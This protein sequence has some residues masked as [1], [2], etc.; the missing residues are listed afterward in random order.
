M[1]S[2]IKNG[3]VIATCDH[4]PDEDDLADRGE[5]AIEETGEVGQVWDGLA[6]SQPVIV[7]TEAEKL[8]AI[9]VAVQSHLDSTAQA[10]GYDSI[11]TAITYAGSPVLKFNGEGIAFR[12][13]RAQCWDTCYQLLA[14]WQA[15][16]IAEMTPAEVVAALPVYTPPT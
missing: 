12:D 5:T 2:I 6:F 9:E 14:Q 7:L 3:T 11:L 13:W 1:P 10:S 4:L 15:G 8:V 16:D